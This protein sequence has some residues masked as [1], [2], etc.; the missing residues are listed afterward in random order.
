MRG[1]AI[2]LGFEPEIGKTA[3]ILEP[4]KRLTILMLV[5]KDGEMVEKKIAVGVMY[6]SDGIHVWNPDIVCTWDTDKDMPNGYNEAAKWSPASKLPE[7]AIRRKAII[8]K[9][10]IKP[11]SAFTEEDIKLLRLDYASQDDPQLLM[12]DYLPVKNF[13]LLYGWWKQHYKSTLKDCDDPMAVIFHLV[14]TGQ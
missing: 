9:Y 13:E 8:T 6:R 1:F 14:P 12:E 10:E 5:E 2:P 3:N 11:L 4:F 7:Y